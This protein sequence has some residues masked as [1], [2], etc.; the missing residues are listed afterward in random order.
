MEWSCLIKVRFPCI[1]SRATRFTLLLKGQRKALPS[2]WRVDPPPMP[3][4]LGKVQLLLV[5]PNFLRHLLFTLR[6]LNLPTLTLNL[7]LLTWIGWWLWWRVYMNAFLYLQIS[8]ILTIIMFSFAWSPLRHS[9]MRFS[10]SL[11]WTISYSCKKGEKAYCEYCEYTIEKGGGHY[12]ARGSAYRKGEHSGFK[13]RK[14]TYN[15]STY[16]F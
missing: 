13:R 2:L 14:L 6:S 7:E 5:F 16:K 15:H 9:W 1:L 4:P 12:R 3:L 8:C 10:V 11:R